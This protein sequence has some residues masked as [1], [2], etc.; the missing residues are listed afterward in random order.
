M[1]FPTTPTQLSKPSLVA[2]I[3]YFFFPVGALSEPLPPV[4]MIL[5]ASPRDAVLDEKK[6][7]DDAH[8]EVGGNAPQVVAA[9]P[10]PLPICGLKL[11][12][13]YRGESFSVHFCF[14]SKF[15]AGAVA[16]VFRSARWMF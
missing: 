1:Q 13:G 14:R 3:K 12:A 15:G 6:L 11:A 9:V 2:A 5:P 7:L 16:G 10:L 4:T 8:S